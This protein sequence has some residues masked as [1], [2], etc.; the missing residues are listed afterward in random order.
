[1]SDGPPAPKRVCCTPDS[2]APPS[3]AHLDPL[4][5]VYRLL[6]HLEDADN[7]E[8]L[9]KTTVDLLSSNLST[10]GFADFVSVMT[11][12][13]RATRTFDCPP[14]LQEQITKVSCE[15]I[16]IHNLG[17]T[18]WPPLWDNSAPFRTAAFQVAAKCIV[19]AAEDNAMFTALDILDVVFA[20]ISC[21]SQPLCDMATVPGFL[22]TMCRV[23]TL[24]YHDLSLRDQANPNPGAALESFTF[25]AVRCLGFLCDPTGFPGTADPG[26]SFAVVTALRH[27]SD[28]LA[29]LLH[30]IRTS[31]SEGLWWSLV[32][33]TKMARSPGVAYNLVSAGAVP[34][35][36]ECIVANCTPPDH[37]LPIATLRD[38]THGRTPQRANAV[39]ACLQA[40]VDNVYSEPYVDCIKRGIEESPQCLGIL[41]TTS[42][43][44]LISELLDPETGGSVLAAQRILTVLGGH[45]QSFL[46]SFASLGILDLLPI[47]MP[48]STP[49]SGPMPNP[50]L[51]LAGGAGA[52]AGVQAEE[53]V[54]HICCR[55]FT[56]DQESKD[57]VQVDHCDVSLRMPATRPAVRLPCLHYMC[58]H[59]L[60]EYVLDSCSRGKDACPTCTLPI[61]GSVEYLRPSC[62]AEL[63]AK[64][65]T[66]TPRFSPLVAATRFKKWGL[67]VDD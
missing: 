50:S 56:Y 22:E 37:C 26:N 8:G 9:L 2:T 5:P 7:K 32:I 21:D 18:F 19:A 10:V 62:L 60:F 42:K 16:T 33:I 63:V 65:E 45:E 3:F 40:I 1:M 54:C 47:F 67:P 39:M 57:E 17:T 43:R 4:D 13:K 38:T 27:N 59:C 30:F 23:L 34:A 36:V 51:D 66:G 29:H 41:Y 46:F 14:T 58:R 24:S 49:K 53:E 25:V 28:A 11:T 52:G 64:L 48:R 20:D 12:V 6:L 31:D 61:L 15:G 44:S 55:P 35:L